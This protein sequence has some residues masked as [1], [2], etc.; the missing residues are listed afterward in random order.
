M[1]KMYEYV[2]NDD[3][4]IIVETDNKHGREI[5]FYVQKDEMH[6]E[7]VFISRKEAHKLAHEIL[8]EL[9]FPTT[10]TNDKLRDMITYLFEAN[11]LISKIAQMNFNGEN[12]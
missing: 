11:N 2:S 3:E 7:E 10:E 5:G 9:G 12:K 1:Y 8:K 4:I 6:Y